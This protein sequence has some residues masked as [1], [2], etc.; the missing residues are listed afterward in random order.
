MR[1]R[2]LPPC[3]SFSLHPIH[4]HVSV[5][6]SSSRRARPFPYKLL[7]NHRTPLPYIV[8][9]LQHVTIDHFPCSASLKTLARR[10]RGKERKK[11]RS[12]EG[13]QNSPMA[14][15]AATD[16][17]RSYYNK[18][19]LLGAAWSASSA[20]SSWA[21][22]PALADSATPHH[23]TLYRAASSSSVKACSDAYA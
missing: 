3:V 8:Y 5:R 11:E 23:T 12:K 10:R 4:K 21:T 13:K 7:I 16:D 15:Q 18:H 14:R 1:F 20:C 19:P 6:R 22:D 17:S 9:Q 2:S